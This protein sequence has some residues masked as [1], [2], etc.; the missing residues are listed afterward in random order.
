MED[1]VI[2]CRKD[3]LNSALMKIR[4]LSPDVTIQEVKGPSDG[5]GFLTCLIYCKVTPRGREVLSRFH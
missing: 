3:R 1:N 2:M 5:P 4:E